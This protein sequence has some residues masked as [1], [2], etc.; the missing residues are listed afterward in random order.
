MLKYILV[1]YA[2]INNNVYYRVMK[3]GS[4]QQNNNSLPPIQQNS[5]SLPHTQPQLP[6]ELTR[7]KES[8]CSGSLD[9]RMVRRGVKKSQSRGGMHFFGGGGPFSTHLGEGG[10][11]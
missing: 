1:K 4:L 2:H 8:K 9:S 5:N 3:D 6:T 11:I 7:C 10:L